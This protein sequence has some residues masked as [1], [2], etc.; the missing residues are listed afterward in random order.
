MCVLSCVR[1]EVQY[2]F[3][4]HSFHILCRDFSSNSSRDLSVEVCRAAFVLLLA[5]TGQ[6]V[7]SMLVRGLTRVCF[8]RLYKT[9]RIAAADFEL[10]FTFIKLTSRLT[11]RR[12]GEHEGVE[13][14]LIVAS[15][16]NQL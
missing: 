2:V 14:A 10:T 13:R 3:L 6:H 8:Q 11:L 7:W 15:S 1:V 4:P 9:L 5:S 16:L 12:K